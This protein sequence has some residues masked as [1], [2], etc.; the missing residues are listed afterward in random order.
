MSTK[1]ED[2][3][4][5]KINRCMDDME[6]AM[7]TGNLD[8]LALVKRLHH[9][10]QQAQ[11]MEN[12]LKLR[13]KIMVREGLEDEYQSTKKKENTPTGI[14][15][16]A[17]EEEEKTNDKL[18]FEVTIKREGEIVY[19]NTAHA[20]VA[21]F[22][23]QVE[24]IDEQGQITG[25]TQKFTFGNPMMM[26]F[27]FDQLKQAIE[28]RGMEIMLSIQTAISQRKFVDPHVKKQLMDFTN[29]KESEN[30]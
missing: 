24:D 18:T 16:I 26:W 17:M 2:T 23:E 29:K 9:I 1:Y 3:I 30:K 27:A 25:N 22:V 5:Y 19:Q 7:K 4:C 28:A 10:R 6:K 20:G 21:C 11:K 8:G 14:N 12:G 15:K 13:K